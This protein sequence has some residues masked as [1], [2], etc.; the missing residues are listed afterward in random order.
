MIFFV[1]VFVYLMVDDFIEV[2][3]NFVDIEW[4]IFWVSGVGG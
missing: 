3:V 4:D 2:E 1:L